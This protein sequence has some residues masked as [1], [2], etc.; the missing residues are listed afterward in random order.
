MELPGRCRYFIVV[1]QEIEKAAFK[2]KHPVSGGQIRA[3]IIQ[4]KEFE[5][6][7]DN[8]TSRNP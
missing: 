3:Y 5:A 6:P 7:A 1:K 4:H 2:W 8:I